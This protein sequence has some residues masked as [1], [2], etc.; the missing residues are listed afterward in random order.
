[1]RWHNLIHFPCGGSLPWRVRIS[2]TT[3]SSEQDILRIPST[4]QLSTVCYEA[5]L[6]SKDDSHKV[7]PQVNRE[8]ALSVN[9]YL[10]DVRVLHDRIFLSTTSKNYGE[11]SP[12]QIEGLTKSELEEF[13]KQSIA[14]AT[15]DILLDRLHRAAEKCI[16]NAPDVFPQY[17]RD[18]I[19]KR[20]TSQPVT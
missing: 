17:V 18:C 11:A 13:I 2:S 6:V 16:K 1:M 15:F 3:A 19:A 10:V 9:K 7:Y 4:L 12:S 20:K 5:I 14:C 8:T